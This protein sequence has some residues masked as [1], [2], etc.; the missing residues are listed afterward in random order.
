MRI[1]DATPSDTKAVAAVART[2]WHAA[3][4]DLFGPETVERTVDEWYDIESLRA[5]IDETGAADAACFLVAESDGEVAGFAN[6]GPAR[7]WENDPDD[8][9][10]FFS[11]LYVAPE[12]WGEG[13]GSRLTARIAEE[14]R[15]AGHERVWLE[16]FEANERGRRFYESVGFEQIGSVDETFG[17]TE[18]TTLHLSAPLSRVVTATPSVE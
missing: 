17:G 9:D 1:R 10:A 2:S 13:V 4:D 5:G 18:V 11:R 8:P 15:E 14:L 3:Y 7:D 16:V 6:A 12:R